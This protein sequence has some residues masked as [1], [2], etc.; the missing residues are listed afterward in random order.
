MKKLRLLITIVTITL[1]LTSVKANMSVPEN[2]EPI[3][4][5]LQGALEK[6]KSRDP[7]AAVEEISNLNEHVQKKQLQKF[8]MSQLR[9]CYTVADLFN[10]LHIHLDYA[11]SWE[12]VMEI[13]S[14]HAYLIPARD[15]LFEVSSGVYFGQPEFINENIEKYYHYC[16]VVKFDPNDYVELLL[17]EHHIRSQIFRTEFSI[18]SN[19]KEPIDSIFGRSYPMACKH[20]AKKLFSLMMSSASENNFDHAFE[21]IKDLEL[22]VEQAHL[23]PNELI[24]DFI[25]KKGNNDTPDILKDLSRISYSELKKTITEGYL[26]KLLAIVPAILHDVDWH[27]LIRYSDEIEKVLRGNLGRDDDITFIIKRM[28]EFQRSRFFQK[29]GILDEGTVNLAQ[30]YEAIM[31]SKQFRESLG[32][33]L[34]KHEFN[35]EEGMY[36]KT[37]YHSILLSPCESILDSSKDLTFSFEAIK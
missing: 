37:P 17:D 23:D 13:L 15:A 9:G 29:T 34:K 22:Y 10:E 16:K 24:H 12:R 33:S 31:R 21:R 8:A 4:I 6:I 5:Q 32:S 2:M 36:F 14:S 25:E 19:K 3:C 11:I 35:C 26:Q 20:K 27:M 1:L 28:T 18:N 30:W 7:N